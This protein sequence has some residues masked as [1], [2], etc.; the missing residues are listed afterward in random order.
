MTA[1]TDVPSFV[2]AHLHLW[3]LRTYHVWLH[4][5][6]PLETFIGPYQPICRDYLLA[7]L[8]D[9][10]G[11]LPVT[12]LVH[13]EAGFDPQDVAGETAWVQSLYDTSGMPQAAV[14]HAD[15]ASPGLDALLDAHAQHAVFRGVRQNLNWDPRPER[16]FIDRDGVMSEPAWRKG[17]A[18][19][20]DRDL[21]FDLQVWP[22][23]L[24]EAAALVADFP[25][26]RVALNHAGF[27]MDRDPEGMALWRSG[28][29]AL[30][31]ASENVVAKI[32][33][34]GMLD[35]RWTTQ[36]I[37]PIVHDVIEIFGPDRVMV[38]SNFPVDRLYSS[39]ADIMLAFTELTASLSPDE[40][41]AVFTGTAERFYRI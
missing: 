9:D 19:L 16:S 26:A 3:D 27:P 10:I 38:G 37:A 25:A 14:G 41:A 39:Y 17:F 34:L 7:D 23:Q 20:V 33:G 22:T 12:K 4:A 28:M 8:L 31:D 18:R 32:S 1:P 30:A 5:D 36:T 35:H 24:A 40:R 29:Q 2:D 21:S 15:L 6:P 11:E 13:I